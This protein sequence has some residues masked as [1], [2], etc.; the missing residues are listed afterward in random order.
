MRKRRRSGDVAAGDEELLALAH[1]MRQAVGDP[2][3]LGEGPTAEAAHASTG[4]ALPAQRTGTARTARGGGAGGAAKAE[5]GVGRRKEPGP[6][7]LAPGDP[8]LADAVLCWA[9]QARAYARERLTSHTL[10]AETAAHRHTEAAR[11]LERTREL[12]R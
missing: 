7:P 10:A 8:G 6:A 12:A 4:G 3:E 1:R 9:A 11:E 2:P 5:R